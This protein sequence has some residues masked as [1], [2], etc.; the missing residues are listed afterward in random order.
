MQETTKEPTAMKSSC[1][2]KV[3][4]V[5]VL[6]MTPLFSVLTT[7][8]RRKCLNCNWPSV[9]GRCFPTN[10]RHSDSSAWNKPSPTAAWQAGTAEHIIRM[11]YYYM[12]ACWLIK[13]TFY[14]L[15]FKSCLACL[16]M[17]CES[18]RIQS[19]CHCHLFNMLLGVFSEPWGV[20]TLYRAE[21]CINNNDCASINSQ[22]WDVA[23]G[24]WL[25]LL[26]T[27]WATTRCR[28]HHTALPQLSLVNWF[29][30]THI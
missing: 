12:N 10:D 14:T 28:V 29:I 19:G 22:Q 20:H 2:K 21:D 18:L 17:F 11:C 1:E 15:S 24:K 13:T 27:R 8:S 16:Q 5:F 30:L 26:P 7:Q 23:V 25:P 9:P 4:V 3:F 6:V